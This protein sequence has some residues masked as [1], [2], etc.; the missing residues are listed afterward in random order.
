MTVDAS[1]KYPQFN[2][3]T[4]GRRPPSQGSTRDAA[5]LLASAALFFAGADLQQL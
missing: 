2:A 5:L 3:F 4:M 1:Y